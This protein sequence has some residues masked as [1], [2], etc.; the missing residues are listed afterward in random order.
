VGLGQAGPVVALVEATGGFDDTMIRRDYT[1]RERMV[2]A[3]R[4]GT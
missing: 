3:R 4:S 2:L 1:G